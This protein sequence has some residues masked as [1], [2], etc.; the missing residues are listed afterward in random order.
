[1]RTIQFIVS[2]LILA[3]TL[4]QEKNNTDQ[5]R[6]IEIINSNGELFIS[7]ENRSSQNSQ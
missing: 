5:K 7:I 2:L 4:A 3:T 6:T 1:M